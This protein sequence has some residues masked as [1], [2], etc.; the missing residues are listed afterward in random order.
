MS[1]RQN[2]QRAWKEV[3]SCSFKLILHSNI[4][5][6][7][8]EVQYKK[9]C[10]FFLFLNIKFAFSYR[11]NLLGCA[12]GVDSNVKNHPNPFGQRLYCLSLNRTG[13]FFHLIKKWMVG[14]ISQ[15]AKSNNLF[16]EREWKNRGVGYPSGGVAVLG[17]GETSF[18][19]FLPSTQSF[20]LF[21]SSLSN[22]QSNFLRR[23]LIKMASFVPVLSKM[24]KLSSDQLLSFV[25]SL[26]S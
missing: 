5:Y 22:L 25:D 26:G 17:E 11:K 18:F 4:C 9:L 3:I 14:C 23:S 1:Y 2:L 15:L 7:Y 12:W 8:A 21:F 19:Y 24:E 16:D 10:F 6:Q 20:S 13:N